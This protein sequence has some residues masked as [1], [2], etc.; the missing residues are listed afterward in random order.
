MRAL[1]LALLAPLLAGAARTQPL[2]VTSIGG[3]WNTDGTITLNW[4]LPADPSVTGLRIFRERLDIFDEIIFDIVGL[5]TSYTDTLAHRNASYRY[6]VQ[7]KNASGQLSD[8]VFIE[9]IDDDFGRTHWTCWAAAGDGPPPA[10]PFLLGGSLLLVALL[11][12]G[13]R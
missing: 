4:T 8:A 7:T 5:S 12:R 11:L 3:T 13:R 2:P 9:F 6:W 10:W 1:S